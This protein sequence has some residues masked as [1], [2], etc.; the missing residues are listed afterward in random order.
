MERQIGHPLWSH[1]PFRQVYKTYR[2]CFFLLRLPFW[3]AL[4]AIPFTRPQRKWSFKQSLTLRIAHDILDTQARIGVTDELTLEPG[5]DAER[6]QVMNPFPS[7]LY[8]GPLISSTVKPA[9]IA[10]VWF[11]ARPIELDCTVVLWIHGGAFVTGAGRSDTCGYVSRNMLEFSR[12]GAVFSVQYRLSGYGMMNPFPAALQDVLTAYLYLTRTLQIPARSVV[13][14]GNSSGANLVIAFT[15]Y[16][17]K[18][19]T[20]TGRPLCAVAI[21]PWVVPLQSL[22]D[23]YDPKTLLNHSTEYLPESFHKWGAITYQPPEGLDSSTTLQYVTLLGNPFP[24]SIPIFATFGEREILGPAIM[25]WAEE[26]RGLRGN[27]LEL[28]CDEEGVHAS[29]FI[30]DSM[31]WGKNARKIS[32]MSGD[33]IEKSRTTSNQSHTPSFGAQ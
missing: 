1:T 14:A 29:L 11:P 24:T 26:M 8:Q 27:Q 23:D 28:Y 12:I 16:V 10:G 17:E 3:A 22:D 15:R 20:Q 4:S 33:F 32:V 18:F 30:G 25:A 5:P 19:M 31:G 7:E 9:K 2:L 13:V 6:F 21:S